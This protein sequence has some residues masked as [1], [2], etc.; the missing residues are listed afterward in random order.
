MPKE[1]STGFIRANVP[2][3][4]VTAVTGVAEA[5]T[6]IT[7]IDTRILGFTYVIEKL[8]FISSSIATGGGATITFELRRGG[9]SGTVLAE[10][11][12]ALADVNA[13]GKEKSIAITAANDALARITD[14]VG[15]SITRKATGTAFT[16][17]EGVFNLCIR[18]RAQARI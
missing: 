9:A 10:L 8:Q 13:V 1:V 18:Q 2:V 15:F 12:L 7:I 17:L 16:K 3:Q 5:N 4:P 14:T 6:A 11:T